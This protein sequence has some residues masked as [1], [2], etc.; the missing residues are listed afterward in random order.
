MKQQAN[1][2]CFERYFEVGDEVFIWLQPYK[3]TYLKPQ[4]H[5]KLAPNFYGPYQ[6]IQHID[7]VSYKLAM[8][9]SSKIHLVFHVSCLKK[10]VGR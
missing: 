8:L 6:V 10:V 4:G 9:T 5:H 2:H 3:Q 7:L 1:Q